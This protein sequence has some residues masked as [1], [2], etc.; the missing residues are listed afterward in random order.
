MKSGILA[1]IF[2]P[3]AGPKTEP[4]KI[5]GRGRGVYL[6]AG[7]RVTEDT[8]LTYSSVW[9]CIKVISETIASLPW[10]AYRR[11]GDDNSQRLRNGIDWLLYRQPNTEITSFTFREIMLAWAL[12]WGNGYAEIV[13]DGSNRVAEFWPIPPHRV[14]PERNASGEIVY[15]VQGESGNDV[16]LPANNMLHL[17][18]LGYDGLTGYS[19]IAMAAKSIGLGMAT[20]QFGSNFFANGTH[21]GVIVSHPGKLSDRANN[22]LKES[23]NE[24]YSGL[25]KSHRLLLLEEAMKIEKVS[26]S[27]TDSQFLETRKFQVAEIARWFRMPL[28]KISDLE[29]STNNNIEHQGIEFATD[30]I[31]PWVSRLEMEVDVKLFAKSKGS[32]YSK[33]N[34]SGLLRGDSKS[35]AEFYKAM[36]DMGVFSAN[37]ILRFEDMNTIGSEGDKRLVQLNQTTLEKIGEEPLVADLVVEENKKHQ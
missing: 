35:R 12:S 27:P 31:L 21:P 24:E 8:A 20:E 36:R 19:V 33:L 29:K 34:M 6:A 26:F 7:V 13:R 28:H 3:K 17:H 32:L 5:K 2:S 16:T 37:D 9:S 10:H 30:T 22:H 18:G 25:G 14:T 23:L 11:V 4:A 15:V 1:S